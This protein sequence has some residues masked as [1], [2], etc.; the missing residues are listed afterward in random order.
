MSCLSVSIARL[1]NSGSNNFAVW[2]VKAPYPS[3]YVLRDCIFPPQLAEIWV[4]WQQMFGGLVDTHYLGEGLVGSGIRQTTGSYSN[5]LMQSLGMSLWRWLF[6]GEILS[7]LER[8]RGLAM[9]S[10][11][12]LRLQLEVREPELIG[13]PWEIMQPEA[14]HSAI[15]LN[16]EVLFSRTINQ[17]EPIANLSADSSLNV[18]LVLGY[19][20]NL[21]LEKE[22]TILEKILL[23]SSPPGGYYISNCS[24]KKLLQPTP[25]QLI[26]EL[27]T[28]AYNVIF[29][30]GH[31]LPNP[32]GGLLYL[33]EEQYL[34]G[35]ELGQVLARSGIKLAVF[36][37]CWGAQPA[38]YQKAIPTS[39][40]A[41]VLI[42]HGVPAVLAMRD[43]I[44]DQESRSFIQ[45][46][47]QALRM[48]EAIDAAVAVARQ[49]LLA[50]YKF[51]Q[52]AWTLPVL[53][54]HPDFSGQLIRS[55]DEGITELPDLTTGINVPQSSAVL[56]SVS[57]QGQ[58]CSLRSDVTRIGRTKDNDLVIPQVYVSK[59]HAEILCRTILDGSQP[60]VTYHL[61]DCSTYGTTWYLN[62]YGWQRVLREEVVLKSGMKLKFGSAKGETWEF[63]IFDG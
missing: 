52:P 63:L 34:N 25:K 60:V 49:K 56:R 38:V 59:H 14:G 35:I 22:A 33:T 47:A 41:E 45:G 57:P 46:F 31:G 21:E 19:N 11:Q 6:D 39:S 5:R 13:L 24:V 1:V 30:A 48:G 43:E 12:R 40:L 7:S 58:S 20:G 23:E 44:A 27:E 28:K 4:E 37:A 54:L 15:S 55:V 29:Y 51:N 18:L 3:G 50:I 62:D 26:Q 61:Q 16:Q 17:V 53:Y 8:S 9:G 32:E 10:G 42:C 36:N 2:V